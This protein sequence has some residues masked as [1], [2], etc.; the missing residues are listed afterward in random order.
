MFPASGFTT[1]RAKE[2]ATAASTAFPPAPRTSSP[3]SDACR[4]VV[5]T[6]ASALETIWACCESDQSEGQCVKRV[7]DDALPASGGKTEEDM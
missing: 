5:A 6:I 1:A 4:S 7:T 3:T 2:T